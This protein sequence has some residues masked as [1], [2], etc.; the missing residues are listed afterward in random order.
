M[1]L[2]SSASEKKRWFF[3]LL[4]TRV[5]ERSSDLLGWVLAF[6]AL[7]TNGCIVPKCISQYTQMEVHEG[8]PAPPGPGR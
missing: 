3:I 7:L 2:I 5:D 6:F 1:F 8:I 4:T